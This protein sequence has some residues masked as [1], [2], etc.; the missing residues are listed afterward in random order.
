MEKVARVITRCSLSL[1]VKKMLGGF[2]PLKFSKSKKNIIHLAQFSSNFLP[3]R[4]KE[5]VCPA[6]R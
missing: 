2:L 4:T 5:I 1:L 6:I 3:D